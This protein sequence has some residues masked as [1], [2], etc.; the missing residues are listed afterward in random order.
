M[1]GR[2]TPTPTPTKQNT[3]EH[4]TGTGWRLP[5]AGIRAGTSGA[6][7]GRTASLSGARSNPRGR[8][9]TPNVAPAGRTNDRKA[10]ALSLFTFSDERLPTF[11]GG[12]HEDHIDAWHAVRHST[13]V[14]HWAAAA[15]AASYARHAGARTDLHGAPTDIQR[16]CREVGI[17]KS[18]FSQLSKT[19]EVFSQ[20]VCTG[21]NTLVR[22]SS[23]EFKHFLV[24]ANYSD[25]PVAAVQAARDEGWSANE[26]YRR[27]RKERH[28]KQIKTEA[29]R[30][31]AGGRYQ[32]CVADPPWQYDNAGFEQSAEAKY[33]T[34]PVDEIVSLPER[35]RTFP[36]RTKNGVLF[37]WVTA[38][39]MSEGLTVLNGWGY[40]YQNQM[41]WRKPRAPEPRGA[42]DPQ[43]PDRPQARRD[44][45]HRTERRSLA[46]APSLHR[47]RPASS[48]DQRPRGAGHGHQ[49]DLRARRPAERWRG[50]AGGLRAHQHAQQG[51][52]PGVPSAG[53]GGRGGQR[54]RVLRLCRDVDAA[55]ERP[56]Q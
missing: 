28:Q 6:L 41:I 16:F 13:R 23:L 20:L 29:D 38:P 42:R 45:R 32:V 40:D 54:D 4:G 15:I 18:Q 22:D 47:R 46:G 39:M 8:G 12:T 52:R 24:A 1:D 19:Y 51:R 33:P 17:T 43:G 9:V 25:D 7:N 11:G 44:Q 53:A 48:G 5:N 21:A 26:L 36:K 27:L 2:P 14:F 34:M 49:R 35:D 10:D 37:L 56:C 30:A 31:V 3:R 55:G 50:H